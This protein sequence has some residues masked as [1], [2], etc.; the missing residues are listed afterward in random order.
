MTLYIIIMRA[1]TLNM[2]KGRGA[3]KM[4]L[5]EVEG[6]G[7]SGKYYWTWDIKD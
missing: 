2:G 7:V 5:Y 1:M 4:W 3:G 6:R